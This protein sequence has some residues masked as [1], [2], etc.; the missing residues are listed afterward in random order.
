MT[1][2]V[3]RPKTFG[4]P[5]KI[6]QVRHQ[7]R[8]LQHPTDTKTPSE[9]A[10]HRYRRLPAEQAG[11]SG[12]ADRELLHAEQSPDGIQRGDVHV[13][14]G[15][16]PAGDGACF[17]DGQCHPFSLVEGGGTHPLAAGPVNPASCTGRADRDGAAGG[18][19]KN[20]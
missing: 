15:V 4:V 14:M 6:P 8:P 18:C 20:L 1:S 13:S 19:Q 7:G 5:H 12:R 17:Y 10:Q 3:S 2:Y 16:H 11:V 9:Q